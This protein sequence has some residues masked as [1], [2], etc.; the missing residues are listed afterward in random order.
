MYKREPAPSASVMMLSRT[1]AETPVRG[2]HGDRTVTNPFMTVTFVSVT[3]DPQPG[4][5]SPGARGG[6]AGQRMR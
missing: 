4:T 1:R 6:V 5:V 2:A 3:I